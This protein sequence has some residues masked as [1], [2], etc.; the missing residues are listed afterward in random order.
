[1]IRSRLA[2][3]VLCFGF[4]ALG[5]ASGLGGAA[6]FAQQVRPT[7][8]GRAHKV[9]VDS[10]PQ[11]AAVYWSAGSGPLSGQPKDYGIAGYTPI[12]LKVPRG[13]AT[14]VIELQGFKP[15]QK[16]LD[17]KKSQTI[18][19]TLER[20]PAMAKLDLPTT[21]ATA[22]GA[23]VKIDGV[24]RGT[25]PGVFEV[26]AGRH[27]VEVNKAGMKPWTQWFEPAEGEH[28]THDVTLAPVQA[29]SGTLIVTSDAGGDVYVDGV[30][31]DVAPTS[32]MLPAGEHVVEVR[33]DG[34]P[35][36]RQTATVAS[37]QETKVAATFGAA[38]VT[39]SLRI[40]ASEIDTEVYIDGEDKGRS[41]VNA[42]DLSPGEHIVE[43]R[44]V[45]FKAVQDTVR[46]KAGESTVVQLKMELAPLDRPHGSLKVQSPVPNAE[47]F[48]DGASLGRSPV[49]RNDL[50]PGKH[51][52]LVHKDGYTDYK[53]DVILIENQPITLVADLSATGSIRVL[54]APEGAEV[55]IDGELIGKTP[56]QRDGHAVGSHVLEV[57]LKGFFMAKQTIKIEGGRENLFSFDLK[58]IPTGPTP[59]Q[60]AKRKAGMS[61]FGAK[62]NPVGGV[63]TDFGFG[64][65]YIFMAR[66]TVGA[67]NVKPLGL[68]IG[69]EFKTFFQIYEFSGHGRLQLVE[70]GPLSIAARGDVGG[71]FGPSGRNT[72][73]ADIEPVASLAFSNVATVSVSARWSLWT[74]RFCPSQ[75]EV[76]NGVGQSDYCKDPTTAEAVLGPGAPDR[77]ISG[78]RLLIGFAA[79]A[80]LNQ[81]VS[82]FAQV[83][84]V[85]GLAPAP[86]LAYLD[87]ANSVLFE[88]DPLVYGTLGLSLK[89]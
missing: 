14:F 21:D 82:V 37:G 59:E 58:P 27:Q 4:V 57:D 13:A 61:S 31:K 88:K 33:K 64:Y 44:K 19:V 80:S 54:S 48:V 3:A 56:I 68:D 87:K 77:R 71:G 18:N 55:R 6:A 47:V 2:A 28:L 66:A 35:A 8:K 83:E 11:Q 81:L 85:P 34:A 63:T 75:L 17:I 67:F 49:D 62:V 52:V 22:T 29:A 25:L 74:D 26:A 40:V 70:T 24:S 42:T 51:S 86:R 39:G 41:P 60:S 78:S 16:A 15:Q 65:P 69:V 30:R 84:F 79:V 72:Y 50:D 53:R 45:R 76:D 5:S 10:S 7:V 43:G 23:D 73:F 12:T 89:F 20:A 36:W 9:K 38:K 1:M 32:L 46:V